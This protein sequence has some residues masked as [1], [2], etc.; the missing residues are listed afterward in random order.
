MSKL[1]YRADID[2]LRAV[3]VLAVLFYHAKFAGF[4][5]GYVGVDVFFVIS[6]YLI[7]GIIWQQLHTDRFSIAHFY[8]RRIRRIFPALYLLLLFVLLGAFWL[9]TPEKL[10][11]VAKSALATI[12]FSSN[13][14]FWSESG[15]FDTPSALKPLLHTW[16]LA[17]EEQ[18]YV[19][20]PWFLW[21]GWRYLRPHFKKIFWLVFFLSFAGGLAALKSDPS[22]AFYFAHWRAW[23]LMVGGALALQYVPPLRNARQKEAAS[24]L[25][26]AFIL[27]SVFLLQEESLFP[28]WNALWPVLGTAALIH[29]NSPGGKTQVGRWLSHPVA[30]FIGKISYSLYL[31]HWPLLLYARTYFLRPLTVWETWFVLLLSGLAA[32]FSWRW[33]E[34]PFRRRDFLSRK[35]VFQFGGALMLLFGAVTG[36]LWRHTVNTGVEFPPEYASYRCIYDAKHQIKDAPLVACKLG[37][38][39]APARFAI[40]GDSHSN[41][42][43]PAIQHAAANNNV[44]GFLLPDSGCLPLEG[45]ELVNLECARHCERALRYIETQPEI[46]TVFIVSFWHGY[47]NKPL[48]DAAGE[49]PPNADFTTLLEAGLRRTVETLQSRGYTPV[50]VYPIP[51]ATYPVQDAWYVAARTNRD[52]N[53]LVARSWDEYLQEAGDVR[54]LIR[55][56][57]DEYQLATIDPAP[58]LCPDGQCRVADANAPLYYDTN[59]LSIYGAQTL[60]PLFERYFQQSFSP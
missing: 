32:F 20:Y 51:T 57:A 15:Y 44:Q 54:D 25:G 21:L 13:I 43:S 16:S 24:F 52:V 11:G 26:A 30:V 31:W 48:W 23:E 60:T 27:G 41:A 35:A 29:S 59:H 34:N 5:G 49:I 45:V 18:F 7:T 56:V 10:I 14:L 58:M 3:A 8:E 4:S 46:E 37:A 22:A 6:G 53:V 33:I 38:P 55:R 2:G 47:R 19:V 9:Y 1:R 12:G 42:L 50:L 40:L 36:W 39:Q 17:V 28:G